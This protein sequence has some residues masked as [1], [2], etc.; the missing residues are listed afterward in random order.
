MYTRIESMKQLVVLLNRV[1]SIYELPNHAEFFQMNST[2]FLKHKLNLGFPGS[3]QF[4][5]QVNPEA[6]IVSARLQTRLAL[7][8]DWTTTPRHA[9]T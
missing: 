5:R 6:D 8:P 1:E 2:S 4:S 7:T 9:K 3:I